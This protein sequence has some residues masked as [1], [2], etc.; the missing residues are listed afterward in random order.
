MYQ[1]V[2]KCTRV[3]KNVPNCIECTREYKSVPEFTNV[4]QSLLGCTKVYQSVLRCTKVYQSLLG[5]T[6]VYQSVLGWW[7]Y[8]FC[9]TGVTTMPHCAI[10]SPSY[11]TCVTNLWIGEGEGTFLKLDGV[12]KLFK[13]GIEIKSTLWLFELFD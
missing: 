2:P 8:S 5:C 1:S 6:K 13:G 7:I 3:Y 12:G 9:L 4:Y 10:F 11:W